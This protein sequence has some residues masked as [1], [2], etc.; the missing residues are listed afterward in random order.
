MGVTK[1]KPPEEKKKVAKS[2]KIEKPKVEIK[3]IVRVAGTDL[4]GE[5]QLIRALKGIKG[6]SHTMGKAIC[7]ASGFDPKTKLGS[8]NENEIKKIEEVIKDPVKFGIP[9]YLVNRMKDI[10]TGKPVHLTGSDLEVARKFDIQ[11]MVD[12]KTYKGVRH[13]LGL[14]VRGQRTRSSFRRGRV[15]GVVRKAIRIAMLKK[16]EEEKKK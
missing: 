16:E 3:A 12:M 10:E 6:I 7:L 11:K 15:V 9:T 2:V 8:L 14:P 4:N 1:V 13:M 5:N